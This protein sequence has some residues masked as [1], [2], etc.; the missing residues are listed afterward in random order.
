MSNLHLTVINE[1][2][3]YQRLRRISFQCYSGI[4]GK[5]EAKGRIAGVCGQV[6]RAEAGRT[7]EEPAP[8][9]ELVECAGE[10][11][12]YH[13]TRWDEEKPLLPWVVERPDGRKARFAE[14]DAAWRFILSS[15]SESV[16]HACKYEGWK[17][18]PD[19]EESGPG[20]VH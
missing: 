1:S 19:S 8:P 7:M 4:I 16:Y 13:L 5:E 11:L 6:S 2:A 9:S 15:Q 10:V 20:S 12:D 18:Y 17:L 3:V 14:E